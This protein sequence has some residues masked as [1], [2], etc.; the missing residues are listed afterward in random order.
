MTLKHSL[1]K[2]WKRVTESRYTLAF[3][4]ISIIQ[5]VTLIILQIRI[6]SRNID[7]LIY[8][9]DKECPL[10]VNTFSLLMIENAMFVI[11]NFYQL[12]FC[13]NAVSILCMYISVLY[14]FMT[15]PFFN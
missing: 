15:L 6:L 11:F 12:Y 4:V 13:L 1:S 9:E 10:A 3:V 2:K 5:T 7:L 14:L 8:V